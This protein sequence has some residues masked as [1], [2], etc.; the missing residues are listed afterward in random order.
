M[1]L[2]TLVSDVV[3]IST[4]VLQENVS[5]SKRAGW[6]SQAI[7]NRSSAILTYSSSEAMTFTFS[8]AM[9]AIN[10]TSEIAEA[11]HVIK[12]LVYPMEPGTIPPTIC[13]LTYP[14]GRFDNWMCVCSGVDVSHPTPIYSNSE[15]TFHAVFTVSLIEVDLENT[16]ATQFSGS[17]NNASSKYK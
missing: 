2:L 1:A 8:F 3:N 10:D 9:Y 7:M 12:G 14:S 17:I 11:S 6:N 15:E 13:Y 5:Y 4:D 16:P